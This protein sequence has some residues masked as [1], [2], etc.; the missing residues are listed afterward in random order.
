MKV[1]L[2]RF[3]DC[4]DRFKVGFR[5]VSFLEQ[6]RNASVCR[7]GLAFDDKNDFPTLFLMT[8]STLDADSMNDRVGRTRSEC[9][10]QQT[11]ME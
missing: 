7:S 4:M 3:S 11:T 1:V 6:K 2:V 10:Q 5:N 9:H 8:L